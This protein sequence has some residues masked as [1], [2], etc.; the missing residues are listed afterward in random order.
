METQSSLGWKRPQRSPHSNPLHR[1]GHWRE[2]SPRLEPGEKQQGSPSTPTVPAE[3]SEGSQNNVCRACLTQTCSEA[4]APSLPSVLPAFFLPPG[5]LFKRLIPAAGKFVQASVAPRRWRGWPGQ[6]SSD[7]NPE[8]SGSPPLQGH[9]G[10]E[11]WAE[12][13]GSLWE[14]STAGPGNTSGFLLLSPPAPGCEC[15]VIQRGII[16]RGDK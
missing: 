13:G 12:E 14:S 8:F 10:T 9:P 1:Q 3:S 7:E 6:R 15:C 16:V 5:L 2:V 4:D 11:G